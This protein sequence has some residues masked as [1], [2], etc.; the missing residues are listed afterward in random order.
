MDERYAALIIDLKQSKKID[1]NSKVEAKTKLGYSINCINRCL[2]KQIVAPLVFSKGDSIQGL[3]LDIESA[4]SS[5]F[6]MKYL[7]YPYEIRCGIG[8]GEID[9]IH[10]EKFFQEHKMVN[11]NIYD[12]ESY[13]YANY[14]IELAKESHHDFLIFSTDQNRLNSGA[15]EE[16]CA[17]LNE[18]IAGAQ[19]LESGISK[20]RKEAFILANILCPIVHLV[21]NEDEVNFFVKSSLKKYELKS[22]NSK[23]FEIYSVFNEQYLKFIATKKRMRVGMTNEIKRYDLLFGDP[24][25]SFMRNVFTELIGFTEENNRQIIKNGKFNEIRKLQKAA[26]EFSKNIGRHV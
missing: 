3:F 22:Q 20:K 13:H 1:D 5:F 26:I 12:G 24:F 21:Y 15:I 17:I 25:P 14:A 16:Q 10:K 8:Y 9:S 11:S 23:V 2:N 18:I 19:E 6:I 4:V 7:L